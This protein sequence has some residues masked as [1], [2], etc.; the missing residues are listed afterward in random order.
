[1]LLRSLTIHLSSPRIFAQRA[2]T[3]EANLQVEL[4]KLTYS[5]PRLSHMYG[6][7]A[8][9]RGGAVGNKGSGETQLEL[10]RRQIEDKIV[11]LK[12]ELEQVEINRGIQRKQRERTAATPFAFRIHTK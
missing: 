5:L 9:Q 2:Q 11:Q 6:D 8:R 10:D 7:M 3:K 4:A 12:K 1:M